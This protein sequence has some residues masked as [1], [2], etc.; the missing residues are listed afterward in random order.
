MDFRL[1]PTNPA[2][3]LAIVTFSVYLDRNVFIFEYFYPEASRNQG[4][5]VFKMEEETR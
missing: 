2:D 4:R 5:V 1:L 3:R